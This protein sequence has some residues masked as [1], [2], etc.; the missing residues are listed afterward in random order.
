MKI[1]KVEEQN[2]FLYRWLKNRENR[3][4]STLRLFWK[5]AKESG[6]GIRVLVMARRWTGRRYESFGKHN[7]K[8]IRSDRSVKTVTVFL[9]HHLEVVGTVTKTTATNAMAVVVVVVVVTKTTVLITLPR[10]Q[11]KRRHFLDVDELVR[12]F[13][14]VEVGFCLLCRYSCFLIR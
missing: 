9:G 10:V 13:V 8:R 5:I 7:R 11:D 6:S 3:F 14:A 2:R 1:T 4:W 12:W